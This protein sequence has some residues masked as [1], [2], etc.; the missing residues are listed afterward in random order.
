M[1]LL[2]ICAC[3]KLLVT[4]FLIKSNWCIYYISLGLEGLDKSL[5]RIL[6]LNLRLKI[7]LA[8]ELYL[9]LEICL[10]R[11]NLNRRLLRLLW[12][13]MLEFLF[14]ILSWNIYVL[15]RPLW[16]ICSIAIKDITI[17]IL[18]N[19]ITIVLNRSLAVIWGNICT[20]FRTYMP[21]LL[22]GSRR[23]HILRI[24]FICYYVYLLWEIYF[25]CNTL[26]VLIFYFMLRNLELNSFLIKW[27]KIHDLGLEWAK[28]F[29]DVDTNLS[30]LWL[31][32]T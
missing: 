8:L 20:N 17:S 22:I 31:R 23:D 16:L 13:I 10:R 27:M 5:W 2:E 1:T 12:C 6:K 15:N 28:N 24:Y 7:S 21:N 29:L 4:V 32:F 9:R 25:W 26:S 11:R 14:I 3:E 30:I 19:Y 18:A